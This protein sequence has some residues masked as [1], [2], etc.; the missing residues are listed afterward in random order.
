MGLVGYYK[1]FIK[2]LSRVA[3]PTT[4]HH[5]IIM[6]VNYFT[7]WVESMPTYLNNVETIARF[8]FNDIITRFG[9]PKS[10]IIDHGSHFCNN[11]MTK[12]GT[13]LKFRHENLSPYYPKANGQVEVVN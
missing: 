13:L 10:I 12:L 5:Y 1:R 3:Y 4:I 8:L 7:K 9:I 2:K 11:I 6:V